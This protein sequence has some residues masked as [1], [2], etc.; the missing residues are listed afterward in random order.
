M[1]RVEDD[2]LTDGERGL[3]ALAVEHLRAAVVE[4][5]FVTETGVDRVRIERAQVAVASAEGELWCLRAS[6]LRW[7]RPSWAPSASLVA[8]WFSPEDAIYDEVGP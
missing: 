1:S 4:Y 8:D 6:L 2:Q 3:L 7:Q 5:Q